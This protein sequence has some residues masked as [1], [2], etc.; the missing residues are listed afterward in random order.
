MVM[1]IPTEENIAD[2][3]TKALPQLQFE[4]LVKIMELHPR[5]TG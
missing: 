5:S 2:L 4:K 1:K 3:F